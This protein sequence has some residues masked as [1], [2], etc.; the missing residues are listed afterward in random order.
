LFVITFSSTVVV[1]LISTWR[2]LT[3]GWLNLDGSH[4]EPWR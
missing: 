1:S 4:D 3:K 2:G